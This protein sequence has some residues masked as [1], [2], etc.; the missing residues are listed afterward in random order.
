MAEQQMAESNR[1]L[2]EHVN[3]MLALTNHIHEAVERQKASKD[4]QQDPHAG[5]LVLRLDGILEGQIAALESHL[6]NLGGGGV[7]AAAKDALG[8]VLGVA[9][10]LYDQVRSETVS[11][12]LRDDYTAL[13]LAAISQTLL[14]T[15]GLAQKDHTTASLADSQLKDITPI[16]VEIS[17]IIPLVVARELAAD[18]ESI[19][20]SVGQ[21]AVRNTQKAWNRTVTG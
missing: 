6:K 17:E 12:M 8:S 5:P 20:P 4:V 11:R 1:S 10:G 14:H 2:R 9:A 13:S 18:G 16:I 3:A 7:L 19:D 15:T 21:Q